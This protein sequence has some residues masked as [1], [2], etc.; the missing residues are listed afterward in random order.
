MKDARHSDSKESELEVSELTSIADQILE[1]YT[2]SEAETASQLVVMPVDEG[3]FHAYWNIDSAGLSQAQHRSAG[4]PEETELTLRAFNLPDGHCGYE[5]AQETKDFYV[6]GP[7]SSDYFELDEHG[8]HIAAVLGMKNRHGHFSPILHSDVVALPEH[9]LPEVVT[10]HKTDLPEAATPAPDEEIFTWHREEHLNSDEVLA[11]VT[12]L[13]EELTSIPELDEASKHATAE[14]AQHE[15]HPCTEGDNPIGEIFGS[16]ETFSEADIVNDVLAELGQIETT[17]TGLELLGS[18]DNPDEGVQPIPAEEFATG[19]PAQFSAP[20][21]TEPLAAS[22]AAHLASNWQHEQLGWCSPIALHAHLVVRG[23]LAPGMQLLIGGEKVTPLPGG[24]F[25]FKR[26]IKNFPQAWDLLLQELPEEQGTS[27][28]PVL[29]IATEADIEHP[30][31]ETHASL[32]IEG[33]VNDATYFKY[34]PQQ[35]KPDKAG[36]F[37]LV[38]ALPNGVLILPNFLLLTESE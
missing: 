23:K 18:P 29:Q 30:L 10:E 20:T 14:A 34:L 15:K 22:T 33:K 19:E 25:Y 31:L 16:H 9:T 3:R 12:Q 28:A 37:R 38:R 4:K 27:L 21:G 1:E 35:V 13:P 7:N 6:Q 26:T 24:R 32:E 5:H 11:K 2:E 8:S 36:R 17:K